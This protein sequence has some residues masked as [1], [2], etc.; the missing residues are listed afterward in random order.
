MSEKK[1]VCH[2]AICKCQYGDVP[3][4]LEVLTQQKV[5]IND[6]G[7]H[8]LVATHMDLGTPFKVKT[9]GQCKLQ[10]TGS[11]FKP[12]MPAIT[13]WDGYFEKTQVKLNQGYPLLEDSKATCA[14]A[15]APCV[16]IT[17]HGQVAEPSS[18]NVEN[19]DE[20]FMSQVFPI[21]NVKEIENPSPYD[22]ISVT[23]NS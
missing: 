17:F 13:A 8:K 3:D 2:G 23:F 11:S 12:C 16:E 19:V 18:Q 22:G 7:S 20:E 4:T 5:Y 14:I 15:G 9:F 1:L 6:S 21:F 10:P